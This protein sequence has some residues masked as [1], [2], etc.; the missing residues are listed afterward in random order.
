MSWF[1]RDLPDI[2]QIAA[3]GEA[4]CCGVNPVRQEN[5][6]DVGHEQSAADRAVRTLLT[7]ARAVQ[8]TCSPGAKAGWPTQRPTRQSSRAVP[9][10]DGLAARSQSALGAEQYV[11]MLPG[12]SSGLPERETTARPFPTVTCR[13]DPHG[14]GSVRAHLPSPANTGSM[15]VRFVVGCD[16]EHHRELTGIVT[17][18]SFLR[19]RGRLSTSVSGEF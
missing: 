17:E 13:A 19:D 8:T 5:E 1:N 12:R 6:S 2:S 10:H 11:P 4:A 3:P 9:H 15:F 18:A 7:M 16:G 14:P